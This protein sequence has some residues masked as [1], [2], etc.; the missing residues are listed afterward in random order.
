MYISY[1]PEANVTR[2]GREKNS[3]TLSD[4]TEYTPEK[5]KPPKDPCEHCRDVSSRKWAECNDGF[6]ICPA[7]MDY[8]H[9]LCVFR[10]AVF[11]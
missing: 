7:K 5:S 10:L 8:E 3:I 11:D 4:G 2:A 9:M 6:G 1:P